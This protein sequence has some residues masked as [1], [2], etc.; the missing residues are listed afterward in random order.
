MSNAKVP[1]GLETLGQNDMR[2]PLF[3]LLDSRRKLRVVR[4][5]RTQ[6]EIKNYDFGP[7]LVSVS[8]NGPW[9]WAPTRSRLTQTVTTVSED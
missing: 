2:A 1:L 5:G 8:I 9:Y 6:F 7:A 4:S 3:G